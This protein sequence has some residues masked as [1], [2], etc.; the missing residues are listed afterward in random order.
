MKKVKAV[1]KPIPIE[2][3]Q[4]DKEVK[5][6]TLE[7]VMTAEPGDWIITGVNGEQYPI[8]DDIFKKTYDIID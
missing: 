2:A 5:I 4:T 6:K 8:K 3:C 1:K 7:G